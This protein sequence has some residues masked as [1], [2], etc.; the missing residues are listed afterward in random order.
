MIFFPKLEKLVKFTPKK[1][2][3][4]QFYFFPNIVVEKTTIFSENNKV[5]FV[6]V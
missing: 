3:I 1:K 6:I 5:I 4:F 2:K